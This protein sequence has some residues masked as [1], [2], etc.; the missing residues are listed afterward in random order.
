MKRNEIDTWIVV[1]FG[2][3]LLA[4]SVR[5][6]AETPVADRIDWPAFLSRHDLVWESLPKVWHEAAFIGNGLVGATIYREGD[7]VLQWDVGRSDVT[8]R[9]SRLAIGRFAVVCDGAAPEGTMRLNLWNA[10]ATGVLRSETADVTWR[11]YTHAE[12]NVTVMEFEN[13]KRGPVRVVYQPLPAIPAR[14]EF[15][16]N[17]IPADKV[18][19]QPQTGKTGDIEWCLQ[20]FKAGG[21]YVVAW[22]EIAKNGKKLFLWTVDYAS[23]GTPNTERA[24]ADVKTALGDGV[25]VLVSSHRAWWNAFWPRGGFISI[26]DTRMESFYWI[27][28]YKMAAGTRPDRPALDL[29]GPWFRR[30]PWPMIWWNLNIQL[31]YW[32]VYAANRLELGESLINMLD[33]GTSNLV[34][35]VPAEWR[36]DSA[37]VGRV[38]SYDCRGGV[39]GKDGEERGN[40]TWTLHNYWLHYRYSGDEMMLKNRLVPLL[41]RAIGYYLHLLKPGPDGRLHLPISL[42]PEYSAKAPDTNYDLS[43]LRWGLQT[44]LACNERLGLNDPLAPKWRETFEKLVPYPVDSATGYMIGAGQPL[45]ESHRHFSHLLMI[46]PLHMVDPESTAD[47]PLIEKSLEHWIG[48]AGALQGYSFTGASAMSSWLG[49]RGINVKLMDEFLDRYVKPNTMYLE[50]GPVIETPLAGAAA[51]HEVLLQS[52]SMEPFGTRV[53]VFPAVPDAWKDV[54]VHRM[55]AEGAFEVSAVRRGGITRFVIIKSLAGN[56]CRV[57]TGLE[58]PVIASG[59]RNFSVSTERDGNGFPLTT[60]DLKKGETVVLMSGKNKLKAGDLLIEPVAPQADR[61]N[62]YGSRKVL[63]VRPDTKG[64]FEAVPKSA[65]LHGTQLLIEQKGGHDNVGRWTD[66][67]EYL[68]WTLVA[69]EA[70]KYTMIA[71]YAATGGGGKMTLEL[72]KKNEGKEER[73]GLLEME[74]QGTGGWDKFQEH[75]IGEIDLPAGTVVLSMRS[76]DG[77]PPMLNLRAIRLIRK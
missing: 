32:P 76:A 56:P 22:G 43:L 14:D 75:S 33:A 61:L 28:M 40:L 60:V 25:D 74:K 52:W 1:L 10:E 11:S 12:R 73:V 63:P 50:A 62:Y 42:S 36:E 24:I 45:A 58:D 4:G 68:S 49:R 17:V 70:G 19:P 29:M 69:P 26:P 3:L 48:F 67:K 27:Q 13:R 64:C 47:R 66:A 57:R 8:D 77:K 5:A 2:F 39:G 15:K 23:T 65:S 46:Y 6:A 20:P 55:L 34:N 71:V 21:G 59:I 38:S 53:R 7:N 16:K 18:N 35:N 37:A 9:G 51:I 44:L 31:T 41:K 30:T 54:T 72:E